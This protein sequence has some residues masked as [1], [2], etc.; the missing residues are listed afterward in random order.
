MSWNNVPLRFLRS[1]AGLVPLPPFVRDY[2]DALLGTEWR[3]YVDH[4][5]FSPAALHWADEAMRHL[6]EHGQLPPDEAEALE[7]VWR[8]VRAGLMPT[9]AQRNQYELACEYEAC[10]RIKATLHVEHWR[11]NG[12]EPGDDELSAGDEVETAERVFK[13]AAMRRFGMT[14]DAVDKMLARRRGA[15]EVLWGTR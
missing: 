8:A 3:E 14:D 13:D 2:G 7:L 15:H 5:Y 10:E 9:K 12:L 11:Q 4:R 1:R 6:A